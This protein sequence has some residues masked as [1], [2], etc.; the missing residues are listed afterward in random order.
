MAVVVVQGGGQRTPSTSMVDG[1]G[2]HRGVQ[3]LLT[4]YGIVDV[5]TIDAV[6]A[7]ASSACSERGHL[8]DIGGLR[9]KHLTIYAHGVAATFLRA[10]LGPIHAAIESAVPGAVETIT[11]YEW[12]ARQTRRLSMPPPEADMG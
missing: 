2:L 12:D 8:C 10:D 3:D 11:V 9:Y 1:D 4:R 5:G 6:V 7:A